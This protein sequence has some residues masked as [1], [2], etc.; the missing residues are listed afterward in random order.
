ME[1]DRYV[2]LGLANVRSPWFR[3]VGRWATAAVL[4]VDFVRCVSAEELRAR[5]AGGRTYSA[6]LID[7]GL[8]ELDRDLIDNGGGIRR[9]HCDRR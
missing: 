4:P 5:L 7:G 9:R 3:E 8:H 1:G 2:V 6:A